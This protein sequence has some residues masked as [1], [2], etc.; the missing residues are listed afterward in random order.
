MSAFSN[1]RHNT[2]SATPG[3]TPTQQIQAQHPLSNSRHNT[4]SAIPGTSPTQQFQAQHPLSNS[5]HITHSAI[6]GTTPTQQFQAQHPL[7][8][9]RHNTHSATPGTTPTQQFQAHHP[10]LC[11]NSTADEDLTIN[12]R[13]R[14]DVIMIRVGQNHI[15]I[16]CTYGI[17]GLEITNIRCIYTYIYGPGQP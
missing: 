2:H 5:R 13:M 7:S 17:F 10:Q 8:N 15:Y 4:H 14:E 12:G 6:P 1:S 16:R 9:S 11:G 3:T